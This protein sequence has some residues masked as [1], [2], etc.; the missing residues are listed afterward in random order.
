MAGK[1]GH[2]NAVHRAWKSLG[3]RLLRK[4]SGTGK[5]GR[6]LKA[7]GAEVAEDIP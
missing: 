3:E 2:R 7:N 5:C 1:A 6:F 4:F